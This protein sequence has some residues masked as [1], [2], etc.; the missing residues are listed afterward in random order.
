MAANRV[1]MA[2]ERCEDRL[3]PSITAVVDGGTLRVSGTAAAAT[4]VVRV[5]QTGPTTFQVFDGASKVGQYTVSKDVVVGLTKA[6]DKLEVAFTQAGFAGKLTAELG[7]GTNW[8]RL[9][10]SAK[11]AT[12]RTGGGAD[13]VLVRSF[14]TVGGLTVST[15]AGPDVVATDGTVRAGELSI[16]MAEAVRLAAG[17]AVDRGTSVSGSTGPTTVA[18]AGKY[19]GP[20]AVVAQAGPLALTA[21]G[22]YLSDL[23][24][25]GVGTVNT[26]GTATGSTVTLTGRVSGVF[27]VTTAAGADAVTVG[28]DAVV[29]K[30]AVISTGEGNDVVAISGLVG[31]WTAGTPTLANALTVEA[32]GGN[33]RV[34]LGGGARLGGEAVVLLGAGDD[35]LTLSPNAVFNRL[36][37]DAGAGT[38]TFAG[39]AKRAG[40]TLLGFE[41]FA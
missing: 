40:L 37:A 36:R 29:S 23:T 24:A 19:G 17:T 38:D 34:E 6:N 32:G 3:A 10:G 8:V 20:T 31:A 12:I 2:V 21:P 11:S 30:A 41:V 9:S 28:P 5:A 16:G 35:R 4:N 33:D 22:T 25:V 15:G 27:R 13:D 7:D 14:T 26:P 39:S 18:L 1:R